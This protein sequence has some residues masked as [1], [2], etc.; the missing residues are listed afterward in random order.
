[1][2]VK[3]AIDNAGFMLALAMGFIILFVIGGLL[4]RLIDWMTP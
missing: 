2:P 4:Y 3:P 1:M